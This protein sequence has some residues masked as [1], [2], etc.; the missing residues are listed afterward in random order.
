MLQLILCHHLIDSVLRIQQSVGLLGE[1][2]STAMK[3]SAQVSLF[4]K[5]KASP[6]TRKTFSSHFT[7]DRWPRQLF[8]C[9]CWERKLKLFRRRRIELR[10]IGPQLRPVLVSGRSLAKAGA[11]KTRKVHSREEQ[12]Q[13]L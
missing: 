3:I 1:K 7:W 11:H 13:L 9:F 2:R 10:F 6:L 4:Q 5:R 12:W 8:M